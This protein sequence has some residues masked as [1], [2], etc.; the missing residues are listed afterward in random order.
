M[1]LKIMEQSKKERKVEVKSEPSV[2]Q[3]NLEIKTEIVEDWKPSR[4]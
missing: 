2:D 1:N 3:Q 4:S